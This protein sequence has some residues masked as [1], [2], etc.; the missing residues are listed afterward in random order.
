M[1]HTTKTTNN[2]HSAH[3]FVWAFSFHNKYKSFK[4]MKQY[5]FVL[6]VGGR[7]FP[8][9]LMSESILNDITK[10]IFAKAITKRVAWSVDKGLAPMQIESFPILEA[11]TMA[12]AMREIHPNEVHPLC[13]WQGLPICVSVLRFDVEN[14]TLNVVNETIVPVS[15]QTPVIFDE[16]CKTWAT[17]TRDFQM[18]KEA[19]NSA[20][21][22]ECLVS[23]AIDDARQSLKR[24]KT[25]AEREQEAN[26]TYTELD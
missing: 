20:P 6:E 17:P 23:K 14:A 10:Y 13:F 16:F 26:N 9:Y 3:T 24:E 22:K 4:A 11:L 15:T 25:P 7:V 12:C 1:G 18:A 5:P 19:A 8:H 2:N 21:K